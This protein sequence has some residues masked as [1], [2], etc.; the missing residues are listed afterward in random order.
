MI[1]SKRQATGRFA[2]SPSG[3]LH[4]GSL[5]AAVGSYLNV[6]QKSG[7]WLVRI[8]D[9]DPARQVQGADTQILKT[10]AKFG[11]H[12]DEAPI[13]QSQRHAR[14][15]E[16]LAT[17]SAQQ[18]TYACCCTRRLIQAQGGFY[19]G[20]C[21]A[22]KRDGQHLAI[23]LHNH[24]PTYYFHDG[25]QGDIFPPLKLAQEDF[26]L[27]RRD[28]QFAYNLVSVIDDIDSQVTEVVRGCDLLAPTARH[29]SLYHHLQQAV[30]QWAHLPLV[31][32]AHGYKLSKQHKAPAIDQQQPG[33]T[34]QAVLQFLGLVI[35]PE[36]YSENCAQ[37]LAY[38]VKKW[39]LKNMPADA[40][41][42]FP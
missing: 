27:R 29:I 33:K 36:V 22:R 28:G 37:L 10:L 7:R 18:D 34:L 42:S 5:V 3:P 15:Q 1:P 23:R 21:R 41:T 4:V 30:P 13:Y 20:T 17:L 2:P 6:K 8:E 40:D 39:H 19:P 12:W 14:Y 9:I 35:P 31:R 26:L 16:V 38:A 24:Y 32:D 25:V 11:L